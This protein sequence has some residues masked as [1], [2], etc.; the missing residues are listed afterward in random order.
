LPLQNA[1]QEIIDE[2]HENGK[3]VTCY[4]S[5]GTVEDWREDADNFHTGAV[6]RVTSSLANERWIDATQ[7]EICGIMSACVEKA[8]GM[9]CDAVEPDNMMTYAVEGTGIDVSEAEQI[10]YNSWFTDEVHTNGM[11]VFS[12]TPLDWSPSS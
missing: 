9:N 5:I 6:G 12:R 11:S 4:T 10:E 8:A 3:G 7:A 2:L 1:G